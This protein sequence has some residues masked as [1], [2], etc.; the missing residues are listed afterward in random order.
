MK[1]CAFTGQ[2]PQSFSFGFN[3]E[4]ES[5]I[6][7]KKAR[8]EQILSLIEN[9]G[10]AHF[11]SGMAIGTDVYAAEIV[12]GL[13]AFYPGI[14]LEC[15][16]PCECQ[17][18]KWPEDLRNRYFDIASKCDT[19]TLVQTHYTQDCKDKCS[20]YMVDHA[21]TW[22]IMPLHGRSCRYADC[23]LEW[24]LQRN[25]KDGQVCAPAGQ[26]SYHHRSEDTSN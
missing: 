11:I 12:L 20:R 6:N 25:R 19:E 18:E 8:R 23:G 17:A 5:C 16:I 22:S 24:K 4:D 26:N 15:T 10:A 13:K 1:T 7:L 3:E 14:T 2:C 21:A 9:K